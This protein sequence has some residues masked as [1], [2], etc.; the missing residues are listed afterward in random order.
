MKTTTACSKC[1]VSGPGLYVGIELSEK[2]WKLGFATSPG[3]KPRLRDVDAW[4]LAKMKQE[5]ARTLERF[6]L[7]P[8]TPVYC[9]YEAGRDGF[10]VHRAL[11]ALGWH[12]VV[13]DSSSIE[14]PRRYRRPKADKLDAGKLVNLLARYQYGEK[15][16][17]KVVRPLA[18]GIEGAQ[19]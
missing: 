14:V 4:D 13:I 8:D 3:Q 19:R 12:N 5:I 9:C 7:P 6:K 10:A 11:D 2:K 15:K 1:N 17:F 16:A 18:P